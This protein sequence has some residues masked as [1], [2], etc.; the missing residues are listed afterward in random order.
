MSP[1]FDTHRGKAPHRSQWNARVCPFINQSCS[2]PKMLTS[3]FLLDSYWIPQLSLFC[4]VLLTT[5]HTPQWYV[6]VMDQTLPHH[7][8]NPPEAFSSVWEKVSGCSPRTASLST[9]LLCHLYCTS[10]TLTNRILLTHCPKGWS[11]ASGC[12]CCLITEVSGKG[13]CLQ[14]FLGLQHSL[15]LHVLTPS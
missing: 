12:Q 5:P 1:C 2:N 7:L 9:P 8:I 6:K 15:C 10:D 13:L 14:D 4:V 11:P 3:S